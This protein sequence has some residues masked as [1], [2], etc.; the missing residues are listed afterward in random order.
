MNMSTGKSLLPY[1][2]GKFKVDT[3]VFK[4]ILGKQLAGSEPLNKLIFVVNSAKMVDHHQSS[5]TSFF[6]IFFFYYFLHLFLGGCTQIH[7]V[8]VHSI[9]HSGS[10]RRKETDSTVKLWSSVQT[11]WLFSFVQRILA[12]YL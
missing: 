5:S 6:I 4:I 3:I 8:T 10:I 11:R 2:R 1:C 12:S 9:V 7:S